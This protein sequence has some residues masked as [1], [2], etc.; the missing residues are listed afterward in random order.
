MSLSDQKM[1]NGDVALPPVNESSS[2]NSAGALSAG[3]QQGSSTPVQVA[4]DNKASSKDTGVSSNPANDHASGQSTPG[5]SLDGLNNQLSVAHLSLPRD[6]QFG[7]VVVGTSMEDKYPESAPVWSGRLSYT[8]Y[9]HVGAAR[10]WILQYSLP[11]KDE[12]EAAGNIGHIEAPW[13]FNIVRPNIPAGVIDADALMIHGFVNQVGRFEALTVVFPPQ[14]SLARFV[15]GTL[16]Q[17][18]FRPATQN[19]QNVKVEVLLIIPEV[20]E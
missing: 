13:P 16:A 8:V 11:R 4:K 20:P 18:Q 3:K 19:G 5:Q 12:A 15:I 7:A 6:G 10:S 9:L 1:A 14:F 17:W 2:S